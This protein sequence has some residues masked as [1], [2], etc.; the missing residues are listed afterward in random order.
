MFPDLML[1]AQHVIESPAPNAVMPVWFLV[2]CFA[3]LVG[4]F[5]LALAWLAFKNL[6][7]EREMEHLERLKAF[8]VGMPF[9]GDAPWW[10]PNRVAAGIG[11][12]VPIFAFATAFLTTRMSHGP[13]DIAI[14]A[15][16]GAVS[17]AAII[18]GSVLAFHLPKPAE[19][20]P[21][22]MTGMDSKPEFDPDAYDTAGRRG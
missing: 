19:P 3:V 12:G 2:G 5:V 21:R 6:R 15:S 13:Q 7:R 16:T 8:D 4:A 22:A 17:V 20:Q 14:W 1:F 10:S 18:C 11:V 9:P